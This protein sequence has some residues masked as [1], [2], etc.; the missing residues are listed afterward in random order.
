MA[1][2]RRVA[3]GGLLTLL[4]TGSVWAGTHSNMVPVVIA[5]DPTAA[6]TPAVPYPSTI[7]VSGET[8]VGKVTVTLTGVTHTFPNDIEAMLVGPG[9]QN[10]VLLADVC[11]GRPGIADVT[12]TFDD[13]G[14]DAFPCSTG[15]Y[16]PVNSG[17][18][19]FPAPAPTPSTATKLSVFSGTNA[20][21]TWS[22]FVS[23]DESQDAGLISGGWSLN[24]AA[25]TAVAVRYFRALPHSQGVAVSWRTTAA[26]TIAGFNV[27]RFSAGK[28]LRLNR[29]VIPAKSGSADGSIYRVLDT[30]VR[31]G[32]SYTYR[33]QVVKLDG[34]RAWFGSSSL[35][36]RST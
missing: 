14:T 9:G 6:P 32:V 20:N 15:T 16:L 31:A 34:T 36:A 13:S 24:I 26:P 25:P 11:G 2:V 18:T 12:L 17:D 35:R 4:I 1:A 10:L 3:F 23:D 5:D 21:G 19:S 22:L 27:Y 30:R 7:A 29:A 8:A 28:K 33:L